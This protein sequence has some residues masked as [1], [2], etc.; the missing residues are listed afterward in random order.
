MRY[1]LQLISLSTLLACAQTPTSPAS[2]AQE[3]NPFGDSQGCFLLFNLK[4]NKMETAVG[5][6]C[7]RRFP[8]CSTFKVPLAVMAFD[9]RVLK[10]EKEVYK[11]DGEKRKLDVWNQNHTPE[12][13]MRESVVWFSQRLTPKLGEKKI[14]KYLNA[15]GYGNK[16]IQA[17]LTDA[18]LKSAAD[19]E[20]A[21]SLNAYEQL[22][23]MK[24]LWKNTL[25][26]SQSS[27]EVTRKLT[28]LETS[29]SGF[30]LSGKTGS[31]IF[32]EDNSKQFGWFISHVSNGEK[33][34]LAVTNLSDVVPA[35]RSSFG[36]LRSKEI[37]KIMLKKHGL[38][39]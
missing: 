26:A 38:W 25:P 29:K 33:E 10:S 8:A 1:T 32:D 17:G 27:M 18:W 6:T 14:Q 21:L 16:N 22:N 3:D 39:D 24:K 9:A 2:S 13:W 23:F 15:F 35:K 37:T 28:Y 34:Y 11:W 12:S 7:E 36:G 5:E 19:P 20:N 31:N 4:T 30:K